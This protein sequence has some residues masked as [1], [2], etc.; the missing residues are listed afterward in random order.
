LT[1]ST[2]LT[3][4][5]SNPHND[6]SAVPRARPSRSYHQCFCSHSPHVSKEES[7]QINQSTAQPILSSPP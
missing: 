1:H 5:K 7:N 3:D 2:C 4:T 6:P